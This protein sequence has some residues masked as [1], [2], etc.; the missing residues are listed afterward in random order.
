MRQHDPHGTGSRLIDTEGEADRTLR[1]LIVG[2][3]RGR[4]LGLV[5]MAVVCMWVR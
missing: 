3:V 1:L 4:L 2:T 5:G